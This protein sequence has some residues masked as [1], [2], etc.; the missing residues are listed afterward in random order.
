MDEEKKI[1]QEV[2]RSSEAGSKLLLAEYQDRLYAIAFGLS[3]DSSHA[4]D[5]V[6]RT[7]ERVLDKVE[8]YS[9]EDS[10]FNWMCVI[11][12]NL[13]RDENRGKVR[14]GTF[15][16]GSVK[17]MDS[18]IEPSESERIVNEVDCGIVRQI[19]EHMPDNMREVLLLH[20]F[21]NQPVAKI[22]KYLSVSQGTVK[23]RLYYAR[24]M[25]A[26]RLGVGIKRGVVAFF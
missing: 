12:L 11:L 23:S 13:H 3:G 2:L 5:L 17:D 1:V 21:D 24:M 14:Q 25:L 15:L 7:V 19:L 9:G 6:L 8:S 22:A 4:E 20:Y 18:F 26:R 10:F 16:A